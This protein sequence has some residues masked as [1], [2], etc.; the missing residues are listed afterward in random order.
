MGERIKNNRNTCLITSF[1]STSTY[2]LYQKGQY[3][4]LQTSF[5]SGC[6][7]SIN[8]MVDACN[9]VLVIIMFCNRRQYLWCIQIL[10][11]TW[12]PHMSNIKN[13]VPLTHSNSSANSVW[14]HKWIL[15]TLWLF[16]W[17]QTEYFSYHSHY[18]VNFLHHYETRQNLLQ[19]YYTF[20]TLSRFQTQ[21]LH[22]FFA[23]PTLLLLQSATYC[24]CT[25]G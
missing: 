13:S 6:S 2:Q 25:H 14:W 10:Y 1:S 5:S 16:W 11:S 4:Q 8:M 20:E 15:I 22:P 3:L 9:P 7:V 18:S 23:A 21:I 12:E 17:S 19:K 24:R